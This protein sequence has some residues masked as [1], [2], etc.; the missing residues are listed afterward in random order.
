MR[1][2]FQIAAFLAALALGRLPAAEVSAEEARRAVG[3]WLRTDPA[4]GCAVRGAAATARTCVTPGGARFHVVRCDGGGF[5]VTS[6]DTEQEPVVAFSEGDDLA[7][8]DANPL[9]ALLVRDFENRARP[10]SGGASLQSV[11]PAGTAASASARKWARLLSTTTLAASSR[12]S[13]V[14]DVRVA[15]LVQ[16]KWGQE[17]V[18]NLSNCYNYYTPNGYPCGCVATSGAQ[19]MRYFEWPRTSVRQASNSYCLVDGVQTNLVMQGGVYDWSKMPLAPGLGIGTEQCQA[20]GRL[21]SD[22]GIA[23]GMSYTKDWAGVGGYMLAR[24]LTGNFGYG[25]ALCYQRQEDLPSETVQAAFISNFD[26]GLP[27]EVSIGGPSGGHSIVGDGYG[28][29]DGTLYYHFNMGWNGSYNAWYAPP[30]LDTGGYSFN[31]LD[32]F[33]YNIYTNSAYAGRTICSGRVLDARG[34]P[35]PNATVT[36]TGARGSAQTVRTNDRGIYAFFL[37]GGSR[38]ATSYT[39]RATFR[40]QSVAGTVAVASCVTTTTTADGMF[41]PAS[42]SVANKC[43]LDIVLTGLDLS[44]PLPTAVLVR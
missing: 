44:K 24:A 19:I 34:A 9:W 33:V 40:D 6:A 2:V 23:L 11:G 1:L 42:G 10:A 3:N 22:L 13:S 32:G 26:A 15:P 21:T 5:V 8:S 20:I 17:K 37:T 14:S 41:Y 28:Y 27:V 16:S 38:W 43:G 36:A 30:A 39:F 7:E 29:S 25:N 4:L 35:V 12:L 18:A 31:A